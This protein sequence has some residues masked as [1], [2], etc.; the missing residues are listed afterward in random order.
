LWE[1]PAGRQVLIETRRLVSFHEKHI[2]A[3]QY[4]ATVLNARASLVLVSEFVNHPPAAEDGDD[5]PRLARVLSHQVLVPQGVTGTD[6]RVLLTYRTKSSGMG[7]ACGMDHTLETE[8][9]SFSK[10]NLGDDS[11]RV[12]FHINA[13]PGKVVTLTKYLTYHTSRSDK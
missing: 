9:E 7:L 3:I 4:R 11:A 10:S 8:C 12:V 6:H 1:T 13:E 5:D 2:A